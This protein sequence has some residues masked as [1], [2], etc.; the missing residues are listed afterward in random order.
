MGGRSDGQLLVSGGA[1]STPSIHTEARHQGTRARASG[2]NTCRAVC[3]HLAGGVDGDRQC[4]LQREAAHA[5]DGVGHTHRADG[6]VARPCR[7]MQGGGKARRGN[8]L[9]NTWVRS[10]HAGPM[11]VWRAPTAPCWGRMKAFRPVPCRPQASGKQGQLLPPPRS[12]MP[13]SL[14]RISWARSTEGRLSSGS[15]MPMNT[16]LDTR[17]KGGG[18]LRRGGGGRRVEGRREP[19]M[20]VGC[21]PSKTERS[22]QA[23]SSGQRL[24]TASMPRPVRRTCPNSSCTVSTWS[25]ISCGSRLRAKPPLPVAQNCKQR[26][27]RGQ[28]ATAG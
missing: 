24:C 13:M 5:A 25:T 23:A 20:W 1:P 12:P 28:A 4:G 15:P 22:A 19:Q 26:L 10:R 17:C 21:R 14:F 18:G 11:V 7:W 27:C 16:M 3:T 9:V 2:G 6:D 8:Q